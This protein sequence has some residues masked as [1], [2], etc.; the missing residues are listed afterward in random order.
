[1]EAQLSEVIS[2]LEFIKEDIEWITC[3]LGWM[4]GVTTISLWVIMG[5]LLKK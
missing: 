5:R 2:L 3:C 4:V 1:M